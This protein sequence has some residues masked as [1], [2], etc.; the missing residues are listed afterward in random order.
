MQLIVFDRIKQTT[1][2]ADFLIY[3]NIFRFKCVSVGRK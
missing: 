3:V 1:N 2:T